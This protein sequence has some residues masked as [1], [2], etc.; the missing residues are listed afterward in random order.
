D[1]AGAAAAMRT[2]LESAGLEPNQIDYVNLHGTATPTN[3]AAECTAVVAVLGSS[4]PASSLKGAVGHTLGAAGAVEAV[5]CLIALEENL[6]PG[7]TG[8]ETLDPKIACDIR[9]ESRPSDLSYIL[10]NA[11]GFGGNNCAIVLS[12]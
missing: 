10:S 8:L 2:A 11:F 4:V 1:G 5:M 6:I 9:A 7:N 3:D 12:R